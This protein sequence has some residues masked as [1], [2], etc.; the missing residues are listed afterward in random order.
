MPILLGF[1]FVALLSSC[2]KDLKNSE[3]FVGTYIGTETVT[4]SITLQIPMVGSISNPINETSTSNF[5]I[6]L[7][8]EDNEIIM[9]SG[10]DRL[11]GTVSGSTVVFDDI[12]ETYYEDGISGNIKVTTSEDINGDKFTYQSI[13]TGDISGSMEGIPVTGTIN[14]TNSGVAT[15]Q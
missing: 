6:I 5:S 2:N 1:C 13:M 8:E 14:A 4:G 9:V 7:G 3:K 11:K 15:K 12:V 10:E